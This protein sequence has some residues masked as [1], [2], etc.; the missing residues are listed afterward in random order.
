[1]RKLLFGAVATAIVALQ[2]TLALAQAKVVP[3]VKSPV[4]PSTPITTTF[5]FNILQAVPCTT[6]AVGLPALPTGVISTA[7]CIGGTPTGV[8]PG[9]SNVPSM[10]FVGNV[11]CLD[12]GPNG[13]FASFVQN[14]PAGTT[15]V[16]QGIKL[17]KVAPLIPKCPDVFPGGTF[18]QTALTGIRTFFPLKFEACGTTFTLQIEFACV[19][20]ASVVN[21]VA[22]RGQVSQVR[23]N[24]FVFTVTITPDTLTNVVQALHA[25]PLGVCEVPCI[26]DEGLFAQLVTLAGNIASANASVGKVGQTALISLN[27]ALD[28]FEAT[29]VKNALFITCVGQATLD[30]TGTIASINPCVIFPTGVLPGNSTIGAFGF[31]IVDTLEN[32]CAC[33]L[34]ADIFCLKAALIGNIDP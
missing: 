21:G 34:I 17:I 13:D 10:S 20:P 33:K 18:V 22:T 6:S 24:K 9:P 23:L 26:T 16:I 19:S 11:L 15:P 30:K 2:P 3:I 8:G 1:M 12:A 31:G 27:N 14:C 4:S 7:T 32:P 25:E 28:T 5:P 29:V